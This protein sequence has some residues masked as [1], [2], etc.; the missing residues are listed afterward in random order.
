VLPQLGL[1]GFFF[2]CSLV[3]VGCEHDRPGCKPLSCEVCTLGNYSKRS[4]LYCPVRMVCP[5][6]RCMAWLDWHAIARHDTSDALLLGHLD[7]HAK[8]TGLAKYCTYAFRELCWIHEIA[9]PLNSYCFLG[10]SICAAYWLHR[11]RS[12][13]AW[14]RRLRN[15][16]NQ[17]EIM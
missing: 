11:N 13:S 6:K 9:W 10:T 15:G 8:L 4:P 7:C 17:C 16:Y 3:V 5:D 14:R 1:G 12:F 2:A